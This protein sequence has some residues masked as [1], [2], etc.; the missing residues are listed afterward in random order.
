M[1]A[2]RGRKKQI[3]EANLALLAAVKSAT[4]IQKGT[5]GTDRQT[6][7][8]VVHGYVVAT[9]DV[10][11]V[12][13]PISGLSVDCCPHSKTLVAA[14]ERCEGDIVFTLENRTLTVKSGR[15]RVP[16]PCI[17]PD[18]LID[19]APDERQGDASPALSHALGQ[20]AAIVE[21]DDDRLFCRPV[22]MS[23]DL[24]QGT[25]KGHVVI[26]IWHGVKPLPDLALPKESAVSIAK[27][28]SVLTGLG[29]GLGTATFWYEDGSFIRTCLFDVKSPNW[30]GILEQKI[31]KEP[32][33]VTQ[34]L[35]DIVKSMLPFLKESLTSTVD[36]NVVS[37]EED[38][39]WA[40]KSAQS[41]FASYDFPLSPIND[42]SVNAQYI[43]MFDN[44]AT[45]C[46]V[47]SFET[48]LFFYGKNVRGVLAGFKDRG[49]SHE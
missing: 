28:P 7:C 1:A 43:L 22:Y 12:G 35:F 41:N 19:L 49:R 26:Q 25:H 33:P 23:A 4:S 9:N 5:G 46:V 8:R 24:A 47:D 38:K 37:F 3:S 27:H 16:V 6:H 39:V 32:T 14:L 31:I 11:I 45:G 21:A 44:L 18:A 36:A 20:V 10:Q 13:V 34:E 17:D 48:K 40:G 30:N 2:A 29:L 15:V 42:F